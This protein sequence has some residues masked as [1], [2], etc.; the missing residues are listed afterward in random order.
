MNAFFASAFAFA[1]IMAVASAFKT[2][3]VGSARSQTFLQVVAKR[4]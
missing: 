3:T 4:G 1:A 2:P